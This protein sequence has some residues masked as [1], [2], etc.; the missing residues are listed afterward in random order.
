MTRTIKKYSRVL[1]GILP[2]IAALVLFYAHHVFAAGTP[3]GTIVT[4]TAT[5]NCM[6]GGVA[7]PPQSA[8][9]SFTVDRRIN[10]TVTKLGDVTTAPTQTNVALPFL[11]TNTGNT[12]LRFALQAQSRG[13]N[14]WSMNNVRIY[15]DN[16]GNGS[17]N[18]GDTLYADAAT[19]GDVLSD[20]TVSVLIIADTPG[21]V[22]AGQSAMYDLIAAAVDAGTLNVSVQTAGPNTGGVDTVFADSAGSA[23][24]DTARD[25]RHSGF[26]VFSVSGSSANVV[27]NK[28][29]T[30]LDQWGGNQPIPG[31]TLRFTIMV[32]VTGSGTANN[33]VITDPLPANTTYIANSLRL[34][35]GALTDVNDGDAGDVGQTT[36]N[37]V[38]VR[39]GNMTSATPAQTIRFDVKIN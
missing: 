36:V 13:T 31:A 5:M 33:V 17:L 12:A 10:M 9:A 21:S 3:A 39:L 22:L 27:L 11:I 29:V 7:Q 15:R 26:G 37:T 16:D 4:S 6:L 25:G 19:F 24:G 23:A 28:T 30:I 20:A 14:T 32:I 38:T 18:A 8:A 2:A 1:G 34:N 35:N